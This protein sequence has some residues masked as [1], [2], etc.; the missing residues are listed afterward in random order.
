MLK[1]RMS[2]STGTTM[3]G[4]L[5]LVAVIPVDGWIRRK[6]GRWQATHRA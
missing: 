2:S 4:L 6:L 3:P 5:T 1:M